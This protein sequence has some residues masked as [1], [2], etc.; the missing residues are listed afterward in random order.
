MLYAESRRPH[1]LPAWLHTRP[2]EGFLFGAAS[3]KAAQRIVPG[4]WLS[5]DL[6]FLAEES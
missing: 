5:R 2:L 3:R 1:L 6:S 4:I